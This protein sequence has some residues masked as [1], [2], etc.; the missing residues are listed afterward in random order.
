MLHFSCW[1]ILRVA[2]FEHGSEKLA[3]AIGFINGSSA[4]S[5]LCCDAS[6]LLVPLGRCCEGL[7][8]HTLASVSVVSSFNSVS[9]IGGSRRYGGRCP[10]RHSPLV[11][12][13]SLSLVIIHIITTDLRSSSIWSIHIQ[14]D[15]VISSQVSR[16]GSV[17]PYRVN[18][19][20]THSVHY[21]VYSS[22]HAFHYGN[23]TLRRKI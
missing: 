21:A 23:Q 16:I 7:P 6:R 10:R 20:Q 13:P 19:Q 9:I 14:R 8:S 17:L 2:C 12:E 4:S 3:L 5:V 15:G 18:S 22:S 11:R 1:R